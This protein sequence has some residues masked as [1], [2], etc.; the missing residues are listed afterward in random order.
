MQDM[1]LGDQL[2]DNHDLFIYSRLIN[3]IPKSA[4]NAVD[5]FQGIFF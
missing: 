5:S 1:Q 2:R 3:L 4:A